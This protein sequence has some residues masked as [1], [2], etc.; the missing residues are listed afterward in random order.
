[1]LADVAQ[2]RGGPAVAA[3][4]AVEAVRRI[5]AIFDAERPLNGLAANERLA[6]RRRDV[7]SQVADLEV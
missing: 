6:V 1:V 7:A 4:L 5:D 3:P 2:G